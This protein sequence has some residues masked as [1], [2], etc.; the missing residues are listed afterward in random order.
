MD[1]GHSF[2][3]YFNECF[4]IVYFL[5]LFS[6]YINGCPALIREKYPHILYVH[7]ASHSFNLALSDSC[8]I[9]AIHNTIG[10]IKETYK[11]VRSSSV[12]T[13][14]FE[15]LARESNEKRKAVI[16]ENIA[17]SSTQI[18]ENKTIELKCRKVKSANV[19]STRSVD[20]HVAIEIFSTLFPAVMELLTNLM[21][22]KDKNAST[23]S[24]L[25]YGEYR[26][27]NFYGHCQ[28]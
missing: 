21:Q 18:S 9:R 17:P 22:S 24:N 8:D 11:F 20:R 28:Y 14:L 16:S 3:R 12:R 23:R 4:Q 15:E 10:T 5:S 13:Q 2:F 1:V 6:G 7:C 25:L 19:C 26:F 27:Q